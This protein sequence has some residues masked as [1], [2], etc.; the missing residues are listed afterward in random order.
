MSEREREGGREGQ[1]ESESQ[2]DEYQRVWILPIAPKINCLSS[3][4]SFDRKQFGRLTFGR[5]AQYKETLLEETTTSQLCRPN[6][7]SA[8][9]DVTV[10]STKYVV[11]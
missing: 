7:V 10:L 1:R 2:E 3:F 6:M 8:N 9:D 4:M 11:G 5:Q